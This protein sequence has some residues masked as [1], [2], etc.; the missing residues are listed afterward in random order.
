MLKIGQSKTLNIQKFRKIQI[1]FKRR[2]FEDI[3]ANV[4]NIILH[5]TLRYFRCYKTIQIN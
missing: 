3:F 1:T 4:T 5:F 2:K